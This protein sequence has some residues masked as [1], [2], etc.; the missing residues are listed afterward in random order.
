[1]LLRTYAL[2]Y[3]RCGSNAQPL[4]PETK[5]AF[6]KFLAQGSFAQF[7]KGLMPLHNRNRPVADRQHRRNNKQNDLWQL[8][9]EK[10][11]LIVLN[12]L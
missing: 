2:N 4:A 8:R 10:T 7:Y 5:I 6:L 12:V 1:M 9:R 11:G 3:P